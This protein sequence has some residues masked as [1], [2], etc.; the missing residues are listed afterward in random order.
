[1]ESFGRY[2][3][4]GKIA[5][6]GMASV[7]F[8]RV[9]GGEGFA[10]TVAV[11]RLHPHLAEDPDFR[12]TLID[13]ARM[14][15]RIHHPNVVPTLDVFSE[16]GEVLVVMEYVRGES[17]ARL[18]R[19]EVGRGPMPLAVASAVAVGALSGLH[20]AHEAKSDRGV[21]LGIVHRDVS[22][23]NIL[24]GADGLARV[25]DFGVAKAAGRLQI[26]R[27]GA[28]K[29]K[30]AYMAPE[31]IAGDAVTP[32]AD[33]YAIGV[34]LWEMLA[35]RRLFSG[36]NEAALVARV[37]AGVEQPPGRYA[38]CLPAALDALV[39]K[40][41]A[42]D[43]AKRFA[44]AREMAAALVEIVPPALSID[45]GR[46]VEESACAAL[47]SQ[48][49]QLAEVE[50]ASGSAGASGEAVTVILAAGAAAEP[51]SLSVET[52]PSALS[53]GR[54]RRV[55][56]SAGLAGGGLLVLAL[57]LAGRGA[58]IARSA[59]PG[60]GATSALTSAAA[61]PAAEQAP[62]APGDRTAP[63]ARASAPAGPEPSPA[64]ASP[65]P[66]PSGAPR[67]TV[68]APASWAAS[69][70]STHPPG[71]VP[72]R[73]SVATNYDAEGQPHFRKICK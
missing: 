52:T 7:H 59:P 31:Q 40:A 61:T 20:A 34:V 56:W 9:R 67:G 8:A 5:S 30:P 43:P 28:V 23:Q 12:A 44:T 73:C 71:S 50:S 47:S 45:V 29:G 33:I 66:Q 38:P 21:P 53:R 25:I 16:A 58:G 60:T 15:A 42:R 18:L 32:L 36:D 49:A 2:T 27:D 65:G 13:E 48:R 19:P 69:P 54:R 10:R 11:K 41:L 22:P 57:T 63:A 55:T 35:S 70:P 37:L 14:A 6:G 46:W 64:A 24:V 62:S 3:I 4:H 68:S 17:L 51:S 26:T 1:M 39:M 72:P